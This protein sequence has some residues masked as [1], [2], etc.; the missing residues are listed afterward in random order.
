MRVCVCIGRVIKEK[1]RKG[2]EKENCTMLG[3]QPGANL[4]FTI[5]HRLVATVV[6]NRANHVMQP[7]QSKGGDV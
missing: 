6:D 7:S 4:C 2:G 5:L 3:V 1:G